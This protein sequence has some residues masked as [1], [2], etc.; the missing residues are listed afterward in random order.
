VKAVV[1][2]YGDGSMSGYKSAGLDDALDVLFVELRDALV[3]QARAKGVVIDPY[4]IVITVTSALSTV[5]V[6]ATVKT[7]PKRVPSAPNPDILD[8]PTGGRPP[9]TPERVS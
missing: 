4:P 6:Q 8:T 7:T 3:A 5:K 9:A 1:H 2:H